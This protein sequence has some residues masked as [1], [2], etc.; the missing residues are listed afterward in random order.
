MSEDR[1]AMI[2]RKLLESFYGSSSTSTKNG[3]TTTTDKSSSEST[4]T[5]ATGPDASSK[6]KGLSNVDGTTTHSTAEPSS[7][8]SSS[9]TKD[10]K[11]AN[12]NDSPLA[13]SN[14]LDSPNFDAFQHN[15][16][17]IALSS[18]HELLD[19]NE[20]I[21]LS[22]KNL[23]SRMQTLV[24][25]NYSKFINATD[26]IQSIGHSVKSSEEGLAKLKAG[27]ERMEKA[28]IQMDNA[29]RQ[30]REAVA[31]KLRVKRLL[32]RLTRL[33]ELP[34]TLQDLIKKQKKYR[35]AI[36]SYLDA[37]QILE[38]HSKGFESLRS[39]ELECSDLVKDMIRTLAQKI[40][41]W[42]GVDERGRRRKVLYGTNTSNTISA[43]LDQLWST[44]PNETGN[45]ASRFAKLLGYK[46]NQ[47]AGASTIDGQNTKD[48][49]NLIAPTTSEEDYDY[50]LR[51]STGASSMDAPQIESISDIFECAGALFYF[52]S[53]PKSY[54]VIVD[55]SEGNTSSN[56]TSEQDEDEQ[57]ESKPLLTGLECKAIALECC[58]KYLENIL[59]EHTVDIQQAKFNAQLNKDVDSPNP[60]NINDSVTDPGSSQSPNALVPTKFLDC[61]LEIASLFG[62]TFRHPGQDSNNSDEDSRLL[63][64]RISSWVNSFLAHVRSMLVEMT[65]EQEKKSSF[66]HDMGEDMN[67]GNGELKDDIDDDD[68]AFA[69]V[70]YAMMQ[71]V[72][73]VRETAS[74]LALP[75]IGLDMELASGLVEQT[76]S[77]TEGV[78]RKRIAQ[79]FQTLKI[80][81][82]R[83]AIVPF[84][85]DAV[86]ATTSK[87]GIDVSLQNNNPLNA[88]AALSDGM[89]FVD[90]T[91]RSVL[92]S[93]GSTARLCDIEMI[94]AAVR[95]NSRKFAIWFAST[96][97]IVAGCDSSEI[98]M[99]LEIAQKSKDEDEPSTAQP[100]MG[101]DS[102][103]SSVNEEEEKNTDKDVSTE[104]TIINEL[105]DDI[106]CA[107]DESLVRL[108]LSALEI[109]RL[110]ERNVPNLI[111]QSIHFSL[112]DEKK[113]AAND[114]FSSSDTPRNTKPGNIGIDSDGLISSRF[115]LAA[116]R[117]LILYAQTKGSDAAVVACDSIVEVSKRA[118]LDIPQE[119]T[120]IPIRILEVVKSAS[121]EWVNLFG[122]EKMAGPVP[123]FMD[124]GDAMMM[125]PHHGLGI[126]N[127]KGLQLDVARMFTEK[128]QIY[129]HSQEIVDDFSRNYLVTL[130]LKIC[131]KAWMEQSR[132][133]SY[134]L[135]YYRQTQVD[136][137]FLKFM[138]PH[139]VPE[140][141]IEALSQLLND[142]IL[143]IG[144]RCNSPE[145][146]G[147]SEYYDEIQ[148]KVLTPYNIVLVFLAEEDAAGEKSKLKR[149]IFS[150]E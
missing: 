52:C 54:A 23:D 75:E 99:T 139:Y 57:E 118:L 50:Y 143:S 10:T 22:I 5:G 122:G 105:F 67:A 2:R 48:D 16:R 146:V 30:S 79:V 47:I 97:E 63:N 46:Q 44:Q 130:M 70:S 104:E 43:V 108:N 94:K 144:E 39:I 131:F 98:Y 141:R 102:D 129:P 100:M 12:S 60:N 107:D 106:D 119:P 71:L 37:I 13:G 6:S 101:E 123:N 74:G 25:E 17:L 109:C 21:A 53:S 58:T 116:S 89:Q 51:S 92:S 86:K 56:T 20:T 121:L 135:Q 45:N 145:H 8:Q 133:F 15:Q 65:L 62:V 36:S 87:K 19:K 91:I 88:N 59:E 140:E 149:C 128:I 32:T 132:Y 137:E 113:S 125:Y 55:E 34:S 49:D 120:D 26:A 114:F 9:S 35:L 124:D 126:G 95:K 115:R 77:I 69:D 41:S 150:E 78:V 96:L 84:V 112:E 82:L 85:K 24:Y 117:A 11:D 38:K 134:S 66:S 4:S 27:M 29:L 72:R 76:V 90:D 42:C 73:S 33:L 111:N 138:L 81:V 142:I 93:S 18:T 3:T 103:I 28:T 61:I 64:E 148:G 40:G 14:D 80:R 68:T 7:M 1:E 136:I 127:A 110:A 31:E 147:A 83:E